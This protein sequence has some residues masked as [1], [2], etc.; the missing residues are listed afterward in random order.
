MRNFPEIP[1]NVWVMLLALLALACIGGLVGALVA[2]GMLRSAS[3]ESTDDDLRTPKLSLHKPVADRTL[4]E[5]RSTLAVSLRSDLAAEP[6]N[7]PP[8]TGA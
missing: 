4:A 3:H 7:D 1:K 8:L 2:V 5:K 6:Q